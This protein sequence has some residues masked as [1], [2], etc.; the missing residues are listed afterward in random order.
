MKDMKRVFIVALFLF[1]IPSV[2]EAQNL[3]IIETVADRLVDSQ[4]LNGSWIN[5]EAYTGS[6]VA[7]LISAYEVT[8]KEEY[9]TAAELGATF[10]IQE[11]G[12]NFYGDEAYALARLSEVTEDANYSDMVKNFYDTIDVNEYILDFGQTYISSAVFYVA[13]HTMA[14]NMVG[15]A[16]AEVWR[17]ALIYFL[18]QV[19]DDTAY[20]PVLCLGVATWSL[21]QTGP[22]DDTMVDAFNVSGQPYWMDVMLSDLPNLLVSNQVE[23]GDEAGSF[24]V[25]FDHTSPG[26][27][28][29]VSGYTEDTIYGVLG[30]EA[31]NGLVIDDTVLDFS[32]NIQNA[33]D[34]L[35][36]S[37]LPAGYVGA[38][39]W[40]GGDRV[41]YTYGGEL[42]QA[43]SK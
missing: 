2:I 8:E 19:A 16:N 17:E 32:T 22:L 39:I 38:H 3:D 6:I 37:V 35:Y 20:C 41:Y 4:R 13:Q 27:G 5:E 15:A 40:S 18:S 21:A 24:Y 1:I 31:C 33:K 29:E 7:G 14:V 28:S 43:I 12:G 36:L 11:S 26:I 34:V 9:L 42:L 10:I 23:S 25:K 30:L